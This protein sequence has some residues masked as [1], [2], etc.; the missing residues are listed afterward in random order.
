MSLIGFIVAGW[1]ADVF[2][3]GFLSSREIFNPVLMVVIFL[4]FALSARIWIH[5][6]L[7][8]LTLGIHLP[9]AFLEMDG[10]LGRFA[11]QTRTRCLGPV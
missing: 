2:V 4:A 5:S 11:S 3:T 9:M 10:F 1:V 6:A 8:V 7:L